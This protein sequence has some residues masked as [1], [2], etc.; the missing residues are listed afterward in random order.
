MESLRFYWRVFRVAFRGWFG[1]ARAGAFFVG[2]V[3]VL[4]RK[5]LG[6]G[7][8]FT[9]NTETIPLYCVVIA[10]LWG[11]L[12]APYHIYAEEKGRADKAERELSE[13]TTPQFAVSF[14]QE[15]GGLTSE[16]DKTEIHEP[17]TYGGIR[18]TPGPIFKAWYLRICVTATSNVS[19]KRCRAFIL[20]LEKQANPHETFIYIH[21]PH[22]ISLENEPFEVMPNIRHMVD[23]MKASERDNKFIRTGYWPNALAD[24][25]ID[26]ATYRF[27]IAVNGDGITAKPIKV[28]VVWRGE[29]DRISAHQVQEA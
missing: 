26:K 22:P 24:A 25:F 7:L 1:L 3:Y 21:L 8:Q 20:S 9:L 28:D 29:W 10:I 2:L 15:R 6:P 27:T 5:L 4:D 12:R 19:V 14:D 13:K 11:V 23:F 18:V 17:G 16:V